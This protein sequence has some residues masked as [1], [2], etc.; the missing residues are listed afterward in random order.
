MPVCGASASCLHPELPLDGCNFC[1]ICRSTDLHGPC[2]VYLGN[3][4]EITYHNSY[5]SCIEK[6]RRSPP[7][8]P[9][10]TEDQNVAAVLRPLLVLKCSL[11]QYK[12]N[13]A[14]AQQFSCG[15]KDC[16]NTVH[17]PCYMAFITSYIFLCYQ[18]PSFVVEWKHIT[19]VQ[20]N[21]K[22]RWDADG[23]NG[24]DTKP[25]SMSILLDWWSTEGNKSKY[26]KGGKDQTGKTKEAYW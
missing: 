12:N 24:P 16:E 7:L 25:N 3:D 8:I 20:W 23:P 22:T 2:G 19:L 9:P 11:Q 6:S 21:K 17:Q 5:L 13:D 1:G 26:S 15:F 4:D 18:M 14:A 10:S